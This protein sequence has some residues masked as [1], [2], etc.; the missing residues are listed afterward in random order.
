M[1]NVVLTLSSSTTN[2]FVIQENWKCWDIERKA[3]DRILGMEYLTF[4]ALSM[5]FCT[6]MLPRNAVVRQ[7]EH[8]LG[9]LSLD[10][11]TLHD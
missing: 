6:Y 9:N 11:W 7:C 5:K 3:T 8:E 1:V 10:S 4:E 2:A